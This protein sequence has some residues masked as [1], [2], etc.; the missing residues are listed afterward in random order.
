VS[1]LNVANGG[2]TPLNAEA[3]TWSAALKAGETFPP[4]MLLLDETSNFYEGATML[5]G[6]PTEAGTFVFTIRATDK[7][8]TG[9]T[10]GDFAEHTFT[11][12][13]SAMQSVSPPTEAFTAPDLPSGSVGAP[14]SVRIRMAGGTPPYHF[15]ESTFVPLPPGLT[16]SDDGE[17]SGTPEATFSGSIF[18]IVTDSSGVVGANVLR[19]PLFLQI[20]PAG[21]T[22]PLNYQTQALEFMV[23]SVGVPYA[24]PLDTILRGGV[25]PF[26]W[27]V[28]SGSLPPGL[29]LLPGSNNVSAYLA[30]IP[31]VAGGDFPFTLKVT[32][33]ATPPKTI[34]IF[35]SP[36]V[37][38]LAI[39]PDTLVPGHVGV[40]YSAQLTPSGGVAPY[41]MGVYPLLDFPPGLTLDANGLLHGTPT[42]AG[43]FAA[44]ILVGDNIDQFGATI[45]RFV[46]DKPAAGNTGEGDAPAVSLP[47]PIHIT[48]TQQSGS[49]APIPIAVSATSARFPGGSDI[50]FGVSLAG[51]PGA[52]LSPNGFPTGAQLPGAVSLVLDHVALDALSVS[53]PV[54]YQ[55]RV[56]PRSTSRW[57]RIQTRR[58]RRRPLTCSTVSRS[59]SRLVSPSSGRPARST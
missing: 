47:T 26:T 53:Y 7:A 33:S 1:T 18:L 58:G 29:N 24:F 42:V 37:F 27:T 59:R 43:N 9:P 34:S 16:L 39:T 48:Y 6:Q 52:S 36:E 21:A 19:M 30:G 22:A 46:I 51:I 13:V 32:D 55:V 57:R 56:R 54:S 17:L 38:P 2:L 49:I 41:Q 35:L 25:A 14:Y 10:V 20:A 40:P 15:T 50:P 44:A 28:E 11:L 3:Y 31:Q 5:A 4:G 23:A 8:T 12:K 45:Y